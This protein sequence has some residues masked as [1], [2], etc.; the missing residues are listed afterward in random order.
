MPEAMLAA[1]AREIPTDQLVITT[2]DCPRLEADNDVIM[3]VEACG[4]CGTD[5]HILGGHS[6]SP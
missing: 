5:L 3:R 4:I 1:V 6:Y 2:V